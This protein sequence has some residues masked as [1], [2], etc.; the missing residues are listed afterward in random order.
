MTRWRRWIIERA[1]FQYGGAH[2]FWLRVALS[3]EVRSAEAALHWYATKHVPRSSLYLY[4]A[5]PRAQFRQEVFN[6]ES[7]WTPRRLPTP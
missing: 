1:A 2:Q 5:R 3:P 6:A 7:Y 4:R